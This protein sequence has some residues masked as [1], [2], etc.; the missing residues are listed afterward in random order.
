MLGLLILSGLRIFLDPSLNLPLQLSDPDDEYSD[1]KTVHVADQLGQQ[2]TVYSTKVIVAGVPLMGIVDSGVNI[3]IMGGIA[4]KQ[5]AS[6]ENV[7][8]TFTWLCCWTYLKK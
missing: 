6:V 2:A 7:V 1:V 8:Y 4:F 5:V 3:S